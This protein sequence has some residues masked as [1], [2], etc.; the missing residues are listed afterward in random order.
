MEAGRDLH[1]SGNTVV[2]PHPGRKNRERRLR[3][4]LEGTVEIKTVAFEPKIVAHS[5]CVFCGT[6]FGGLYLT[7]CPNCKSCQYCGL[8]MPTG[9]SCR[10]CGNHPDKNTRL[11]APRRLQAG[12]RATHSPPKPR[13]NANRIVRRSGPLTRDRR[14]GGLL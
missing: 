14:H 8:F 3:R 13:K 12:I 5:S 2:G 1:Y 6:V 4:L 9:P 7:R 10:F 11:P